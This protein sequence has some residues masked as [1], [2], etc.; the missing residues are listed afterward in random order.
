[1]FEKKYLK[2]ISSEKTQFPRYDRMVKMV[3]YFNKN[4]PFIVIYR[5]KALYN[6]DLY[7]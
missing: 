2:K 5:L 7:L 4:I 3:P 6:T 1:M